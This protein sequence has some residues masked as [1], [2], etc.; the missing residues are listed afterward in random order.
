VCAEIATAQTI[1]ASL[2]TRTSPLAS[3]FRRASFANSSGDLQDVPSTTSQKHDKTDD[4]NIGTKKTGGAQA[5]PNDTE[6]KR[7]TLA[8]R[9]RKF[10]T[11]ERL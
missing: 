11:R 4:L 9:K 10:K 2:T 3:T 1:T 7:G 8:E 6:V 5:G